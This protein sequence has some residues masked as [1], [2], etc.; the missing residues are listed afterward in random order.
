MLVILAPALAPSWRRYVTPTPI[1]PR[2]LD[3]RWGELWRWPRAGTWSGDPTVPPSAGRQQR[4]RGA[5]IQARR[6]N[7]GQV[8]HLEHVLARWRRHRRPP[9]W[10][11]TQR[12]F[13]LR[14]SWEMSGR[15]ITSAY[16]KS[17]SPLTPLAPIKRLE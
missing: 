2:S 14:L 9:P 6:Y 1:L 10:S 7:K 3:V 16:L 4:G 11:H 5:R 8:G 15:R 13:K 12:S 17:G